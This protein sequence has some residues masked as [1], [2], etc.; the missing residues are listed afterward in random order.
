MG[1]IIFIILFIVALVLVWRTYHKIFTVYYFSAQGCLKEIL[2][3]GF[4]SFLIAAIICSILGIK[5]PGINC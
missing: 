1:T 2:T 5:V 4:I 3:V